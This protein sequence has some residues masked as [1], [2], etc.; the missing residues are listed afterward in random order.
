MRSDE[1]ARLAARTIGQQEEERRRLSLELHDETA[2]VF[3]AVKLRLGLLQE[4]ADAA[5]SK[6][7][8]ELVN[9]VDSGM[10]TIRNVTES[11]RPTV[12]DELGIGAAIRSLAA[13][14]SQ[15]TAI[16]TSVNGIDGALEL[17]ADA[18]LAVY[19]AIQEALSNV[20]RHTG[21]T[22]VRVDMER[23]NGSL[24]VRIRDD[25]RG[26][27]ADLDDRRLVFNGHTGL[28]GIRERVQAIGGAVSLGR[29][30]EGGAEVA[31][32]LPLHE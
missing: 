20:A 8:G 4:R 5:T 24:K 1:L 21:A 23:D 31:L 28:A 16:A 3:A 27:P 18:E 26:F 6:Q 7:L 2:Q 29:S 25:G 14:F 32:E 11:L 9:L 17:S 15:R 12:L 30:P 19:R 22:R 13:D 10:S